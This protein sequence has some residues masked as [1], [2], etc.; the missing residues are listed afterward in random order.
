MQC[1]FI[2]VCKFH[3]RKTSVSL[4]I[5]KAHSDIKTAFGSSCAWT[6]K[7]GLFVEGKGQGAVHELCNAKIASF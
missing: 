4:I 6:E 7:A 3:F 1:F 2:I 5:L